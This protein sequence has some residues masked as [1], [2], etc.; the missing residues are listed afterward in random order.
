MFDYLWGL[1]HVRQGANLYFKDTILIFTIVG[2]VVK[3]TK[4]LNFFNF[5]LLALVFVKKLC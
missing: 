5:V 1:Q 3:D 4:Q 2:P